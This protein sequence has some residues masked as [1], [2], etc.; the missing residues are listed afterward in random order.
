MV[1]ARAEAPRWLAL[2]LLGGLLVV[3]AA[4]RLPDLGGMPRGINP[5]E[6][7]RAAT[8]FDVLRGAAP[9]SWFDSGWFMISMVYFRVLASSMAAFGPDVAGGRTLTALL[10]IAF[11]GFVAWLGGRHFGARAGVLAG[12]FATAIP[13]SIQYSRLINEAGPTALLWALSIGGFLEGARGGRAWAWVVAG[14]SGGLSLYFYPSA[15]LWAVG[16]VLTGLVLLAFVRD[17]RLL[18]GLGLTALAS[19]AAA[20]PFLVHLSQ[21]PDEIAA[22]YL[23]TA[24]LDPR[25]QVRLD[26]L[27]PPEPFWRLAALQGERALGMFDRY[28]DGG[29]FLPTGHPLFGMPLAALALVG[30]FYVV[31]RGWRDARMAVLAIWLWVGLLGVA[32][33]V[34][35]PNYLRAVGMLP[36]L[37]CALAVLVLEVI[38]RLAS[39]LPRGPR[40]VLAGAVAAGIVIGLLV[41][42][43]EGYF[44]AFRTL[45]DAW[46]SQNHEGEIIDALGANGPVYSIEMNEHLVSSGWVRLLAPTA[47]RGRVPNPGSELPIV[48]PARPA[49][50]GTVAPEVYPRAD[51]GLSVLLSPDP[52]QMTYV[53]LLQQMYPRAQPGDGGGDGRVSVT[54]SPSALALTQGVTLVSATGAYR[55]VDTFGDIP[56]DLAA[57]VDLT[58]RAGVRLAPGG[59]YRLSVTAPSRVQLRLDGISVLDTTG[60]GE[61]DVLAAD[62]LH[63]V[64]L[65]APVTSVRDRV[66][67]RVD[68]ATL[69]PRQTY[70]PMDAA[71]GLLARVDQPLFN[72]PSLHLA[73]MVAMAFFEPELGPAHS[74]PAN[75]VIWSGALLAPYS[76]TYRMAFAAEDAMHLRVDG[77]PV[78]VVTVSPDGWRDV[79]PGTPVELSAGSHRVEV[80]LDVTHGARELARWNWVPPRADGTPD[81]N[82]AWSVVPPWVLRPDPAVR[83]VD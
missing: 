40:P 28:P 78:D 47:L 3:A 82:A 73:G 48:Q 51:Q 68:G 76:G 61:V 7:D 64:E 81:A 8:A 39:L 72:Q 63:F 58:W 33:T 37:C 66:G 69:S 75:G 70:A 38:D 54:L 10:G 5:D 24:A 4:L 25:N 71:W 20:L 11:V 42:Q 59:R 15:R 22:R 49:E 57:P 83:V 46:A 52:N 32:A 60:A 9:P 1:R 27:T 80:R 53:P 45:P 23:Q 21:Y 17:R 36:S 55:H 79:G 16:A 50:A 14:M 12:A 19:V 13:L 67:L 2:A 44:E 30:V 29:S 56:E 35:T 41:P 65:N 18:P 34:E 43:V 26:Y 74:G 6:G 77:Q 31:V 62:G